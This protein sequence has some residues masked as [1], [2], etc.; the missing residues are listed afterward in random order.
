MWVFNSR[1]DF[2][3]ETDPT[4]GE[5]FVNNDIDRSSALVRETVQNSLDA[6]RS[7][8]DPVEV[9]FTF[10]EGSLFLGP[11]LLRNYMVGLVEHL[12]ACGLD[13]D[14]IGLD[15]PRAIPSGRAAP[16]FAPHPSRPSRPR[17]GA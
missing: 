9:R 15:D 16:P 1:H 14:A 7:D 12:Q 5:F 4:E 17:A 2:G 6:R 11:Y 3:V 13:L 10:H 8:T